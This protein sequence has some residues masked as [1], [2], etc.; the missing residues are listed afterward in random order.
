M[1]A[2]VPSRAGAAPETAPAIAEAAPF[3]PATRAA[4]P[5]ACAAA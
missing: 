5:D 3:D 1:P 2:T 4:S